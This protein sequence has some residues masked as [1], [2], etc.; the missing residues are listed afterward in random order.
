MVL[1]SAP[2]I[3]FSSLRTCSARAGSPLACSSISRSSRLTAKV[4]PA[5]L[6]ACRSIG[7]NRSP[8]K[9][10]QRAQAVA[11]GIAGERHGIGRI[12][13]VGHRGRRRR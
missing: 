8:E 4:T 5:A 1:T 9:V 10:L 13:E 11:G 6:I 12:A 7:A 3:W 2:M